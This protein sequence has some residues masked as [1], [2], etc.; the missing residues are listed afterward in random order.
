M[1]NARDLVTHQQHADKNRQT[2]ALLV[3]GPGCPSIIGAKGQVR[4][5]SRAGGNDRIMRNGFAFVL[6]TAWR[7]PRTTCR[8]RW[9]FLLMEA[10]CCVEEHCLL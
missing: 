5:S 8:Y 6:F 4:A 3:P 1:A 2:E 7:E 10:R 9:Q